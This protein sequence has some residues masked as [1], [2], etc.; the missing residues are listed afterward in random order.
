MNSRAMTKLVAAGSLGWLLVGLPLGPSHAQLATV[1]FPD[2]VVGQTSTV[3]CPTTN[4][5]LCF[6]TNKNQPARLASHATIKEGQL[7]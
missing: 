1:T 3:K 7:S 2:T 6:S 4:V 5:S